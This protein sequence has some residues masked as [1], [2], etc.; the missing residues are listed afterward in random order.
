MKSPSCSLLLSGS[1]TFTMSLQKE[2]FKTAFV[3]LRKICIFANRLYKV[4]FRYD[5]ISDYGV[6]DDFHVTVHSYI[7]F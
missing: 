1:K 4:N 2:E 7:L 6:N 5:V 3:R